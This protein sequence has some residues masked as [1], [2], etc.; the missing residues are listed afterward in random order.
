[1]LDETAAR[2]HHQHLS[3]VH[4]RTNGSLYRSCDFRVYF[5]CI[6]LHQAPDTISSTRNRYFAVERQVCGVSVAM[7]RNEVGPTSVLAYATEEDG[8]IV[9]PIISVDLVVLR[10]ADAASNQCNHGF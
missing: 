2:S 10:I 8:G 3:C 7:K 1:M 5:H 9:G 4:R 6:L